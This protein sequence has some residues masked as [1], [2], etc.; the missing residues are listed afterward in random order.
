[1]LGPHWEIPIYESPRGHLPSSPAEPALANMYCL[2][3]SFGSHM[4]PLSMS[5]AS[6]SLS[7]RASWR[8]KKD[9]LG[10]LTTGKGTKVWSE[11]WLAGCGE[12]TCTGQALRAGDWVNLGSKSS[13]WELNRR[14][15]PAE[16]TSREHQ[17]PGAKVTPTHNCLRQIF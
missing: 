12:W 16:V 6:W 11:T 4:F 5:T 10:S 7:L 3:Q 17:P 15:T 1:M 9:G 13:G 8:V 14:G 2:P